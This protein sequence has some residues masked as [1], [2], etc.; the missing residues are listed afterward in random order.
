MPRT[1]WGDRV[2]IVLN[3]LGIIGRMNVGQI[4]E[5]YCGLIGKELAN[6]ILKETSKTNV[7]DIFKNVLSTLDNTKNKKFST[8]FIKNLRSINRANYELM[9]EQIRKSG[10]AP[11]IVPPFQTPT[12]KNIISTMKL[13]GLKSGYKLF[14]PNYNT[15][16]S[17]EVP[18]GYMYM[19]KLEHMGEAKLHARSTGPVTSKTLQPTGGKSR[20]GGQRIGEMDTYSFLSYNA[21][22][23]LSELMGPM[24]D[25]RTTQNEMIS[26]IIQ[27]GQTEFKTTKMS[28]AKDLLNAYMVSLMLGGGR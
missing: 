25:D 3:P 13:L 19:T 10:F 24:S 18:V 7:V 26:E 16:T 17:Y 20:E 8:D 2:D 15:K 5:L 9:I 12:Y 22:L 27:T 28:P 11:I 14:L 4:Y 1:P 6:R 23:T 21:T